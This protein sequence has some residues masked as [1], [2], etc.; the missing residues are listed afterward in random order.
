MECRTTTAV[1]L[2]GGFSPNDTPHRGYV[3]IRLSVPFI[4]FETCER[5]SRDAELSKKLASSQTR[6]RKS[7]FRRAYVRTQYVYDVMIAVSRAVV[8]S[9]VLQNPKIHRSYSFMEFVK[10]RKDAEKESF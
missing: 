7:C 1:R 6:A 9:P 8:P 2:Y 10:I 3:G 5:L 4:L